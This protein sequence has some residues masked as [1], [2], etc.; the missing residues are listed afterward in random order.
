MYELV[1]RLAKNRM[2]RPFRLCGTCFFRV[3]L[4][5]GF[6]QWKKKERPGVEH[7]RKG[8]IVLGLIK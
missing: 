7:V 6:N 8:E 3:I 1:I 5:K 4:S 2:L